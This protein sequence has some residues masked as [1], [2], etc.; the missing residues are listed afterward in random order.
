MVV[1]GGGALGMQEMIEERWRE[2]KSM[3]ANGEATKKFSVSALLDSLLISIKPSALGLQARLRK[4]CSRQEM[5]SAKSTL[6]TIYN[7]IQK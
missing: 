4:K 6:H 2:V 7:S 5:K 3:E 1:E